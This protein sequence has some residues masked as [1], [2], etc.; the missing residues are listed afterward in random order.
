MSLKSGSVQGSPSVLHRH[1][2]V[3]NSETMHSPDSLRLG[4]KHS[5]FSA[6][7]PVPQLPGFEREGFSAL[8]GA[9]PPGLFLLSQESDTEDSPGV[10]PAS[11]CVFP[12]G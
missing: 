6:S 10:A 7:A 12:E 5:G 2:I 8:E 11:D 3:A 1:N 9:P 4:Q